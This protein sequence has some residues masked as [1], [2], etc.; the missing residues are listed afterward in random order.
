MLS[1]SKQLRTLI[2]SDCKLNDEIGGIILTSLHGSEALKILNLQHNSISEES[3]ESL[4]GLLKRLGSRGKEG[5]L[6]TLILSNNAFKTKLIRN[7]LRLA[8]KTTN[9]LI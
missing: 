7:K 9:V 3:S 1:R 2:L 5:G 8:S 6:K 4:T